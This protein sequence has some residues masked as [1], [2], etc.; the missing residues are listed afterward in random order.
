MVCNDDFD[1]PGQY[2]SYIEATLEPGLYYLAIDSYSDE[3]GEYQID[4]DL[5]DHQC[6]EGST[7]CRDGGLSTCI[8]DNAGCFNW[9]RPEDCIEGTRCRQGNTQC[10]SPP[11]L[12]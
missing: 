7:Q 11:G 3:V 1:P 5:C 2:G 9:S 8:L 10:T 12:L 4:L 6:E